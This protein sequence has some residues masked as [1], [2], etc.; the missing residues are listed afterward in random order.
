MSNKT[1]TGLEAFFMAVIQQ[2]GNNLPQRPI[3]DFLGGTVA[4]DP[5]NNRTLVT[6][7]AGAGAPA[8]LAANFTQPAV[9]ASVSAQ[10]S[11]SGAFAPGEVI[12]IQGG[13]F[14]SVSSIPDGT[15]LSLVNVGGP[16]QTAPGNTVTSG[17][18][19]NSSGPAPLLIQANDAYAVPQRGILDFRGFASFDDA[20][21]TRTVVL[22]VQA[23]FRANHA[24]TPYTLTTVQLNVWADVT[25]GV[26]TLNVPATPTDATELAVTNS[27]G[28][29]SASNITV[30]AGG[31]DT[32]QDPNNPTAA[33]VASVAL[34]VKRSSVRWKY[35]A[36]EALW[37]LQ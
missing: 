22:P 31:A 34:K 1:P 6:L 5:V 13:G 25:G 8:T 7:S 32:L 29:A 36:T 3:I 14:Y 27:A 10:V 30:T 26:I 4:D 20:A 15:H 28:D 33:P 17:V 11:I 21:N 9:L 12:F 37:L 2:N 16:Y 23:I 18:L 24:G 35:G 19:V